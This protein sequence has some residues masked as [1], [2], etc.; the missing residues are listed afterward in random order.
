MIKEVTKTF[1][2]VCSE[3]TQDKSVLTDKEDVFSDSISSV[4]VDFGLGCVR[5]R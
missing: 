4:H 1:S 5:Q 3:N 2:C